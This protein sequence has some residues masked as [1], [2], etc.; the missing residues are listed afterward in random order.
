MPTPKSPAASFVLACV[1]LDALGIGLIIPVLPRLIGELSTDPQS[2]ALWYGCIMTSY[3]LMQFLFA[4]VIGAVSDRI[5]RRPVLLTG[6]FGLAV[7][8]LVPAFSESLPA[9]LASRIFGG[10]LSSNIVVAQAYIAD[11]TP[12]ERR[13]AAF[14]FIGAMFGIAFILG[15]ALGGLLG[16]SDPRVPFMTAGIICACNFLYGWFALPESLK[17][18]DSAPIRLSR[19]NPFSAL[20]SIGREEKLLPILAVAALFTLS[21]GIVQC[22]WALYTEFR[23]GWTPEEIGLS[24]FALGCA[25]TATQGFVLPKLARRLPP[26]PLSLFGLLIGLISLLGTAFAPSGL[27]AGTAV[28]V[29]AVMG[30]VGPTLQS[31]ISRTGSPEEQGVRMGAVSSLNSFTGAVSPL[32]GTPLLLHTTGDAAFALQGVPYLFT[33]LLVALAAAIAL[34]TPFPSVPR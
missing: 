26:K 24:I 31:I 10:I 34:R 16:E 12:T 14:G 22:T 19:C 13:T 20:I 15:P 23:Y 8:M 28:C 7:M 17:V 5:G 32:L 29:F 27:W 33:A 9:I 4:P 1:F 11:V 3:G 18:P 21:Q 25:I 2:Q 6:I 30:V